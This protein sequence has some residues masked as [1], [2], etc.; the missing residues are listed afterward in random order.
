VALQRE[1]RRKE[2]LSPD[3]SPKKYTAYGRALLLHPAERGVV[4]KANGDGQRQLGRVF[5]RGRRRVN[6][7]PSLTMVGMVVIGRRRE[8]SLEEEQ[9]AQS[10]NEG[11]NVLSQ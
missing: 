7:D 1:L 6:P 3:H 8:R 4:N 10:G 5:D 11:R 2:G 9:V